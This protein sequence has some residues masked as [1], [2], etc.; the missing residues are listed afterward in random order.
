MPLKLDRTSAVLVAI[1]ALVIALT[2]PISPASAKKNEVIERYQAHAMSL[3]A[4]AASLLEISIF[5][6]NSVEDRTALIQSFSDGGT[7]GAY[8]HLHK[9]DEMGFVKAPNTMGY[10]MR[11]A[12]K[13]EKDGKEN[14]VMATDRPIGMGEVMQDSWTADNSISLVVIQMD[15][16]TGEGQGEMI[17]GAGFGIDKKTGQL[18]IE[19]IATN[20]IKFKSVKKMKVKGH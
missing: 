20:P 3:S 4:G 6:Y 10:Q 18:T 2:G 12:Y 15:P 7:K 16:D 5:G 11:Y 17:V 9:M 14:I 19:S 8:N 13:Y 1:L